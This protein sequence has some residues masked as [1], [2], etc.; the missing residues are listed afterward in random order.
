MTTVPE[1][2]SGNGFQSKVWGPAAWLFL[3]CVSLNYDPSKHNAI[4]FLNFFK[5]LAYVLPCG[6]CR[7]NYQDLIKSK[8]YRL[9]RNTFQSRK[10]LSQWLFRVH[11]HINRK[12]G[13]ELVYA[14]TED[15]YK[16]MS[17]FYETFRA[18]C[19]TK[20]TELGCI[21]PLHKQ[22]K[23]R[24]VLVLKPAKSKCRSLRKIKM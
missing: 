5:S 12:T 13:K 1:N 3:H 16:Q 9:N 14:N 6:T 24:C 15:G 4:E 21:K 22:N 20:K 11:N 19:E 10:S 7:S 17:Q 18:K 8:K 23:M 2:G